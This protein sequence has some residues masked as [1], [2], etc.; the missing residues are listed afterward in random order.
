MD[1]KLDRE[2]KKI[3][4]E[5]EGQE[6]VLDEFRTEQDNVSKELSSI[7]TKLHLKQDKSEAGKI[8]QYFERFA[9]YDDLRDL[10]NKTLPELGKFE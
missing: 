6:A 3:N 8:W 9:L 7:S 1:D 4:K 5:I 10:Y 2:F